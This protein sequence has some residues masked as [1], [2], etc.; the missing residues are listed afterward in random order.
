MKGN[1]DI[2]HWIAAGFL[3]L[4]LLI[5]PADC[6]AGVAVS[7]LKQWVEVKP[8][9]DALFSVD[10]TNTNRGPETRPST[11]SVDVVDFTVS[12]QGGLS[13]GEEFK[14]DRSAVDWISFNA[15]KLVL[16]PGETK[17]IKA[18]LSAPPSADGDYWAAIMVTLGNS[19]KQ[20]KGIQVVLR[21]ASG[22]FVHV[23]RR[24]YIARGDIIN[25]TVAIP[26]SYPEQVLTEELTWDQSS[27]EVQKEQAL[28]I[29]VELK[30][31]GLVTFLANGK[32]FL[33][34]GNWRRM[35]SIPLHTN[36]RRIFP[37]HSRYF[38]GVMSQPLP[39]GEYKLRLFFEPDSK[40]GRKITKDMEFSVS[41]ESARQW[42]E[43]FSRDDIQMMEVEPQQIKLTL[44]PGRLTATRFLVVNQGLST[45]A[46][47]CWLEEN[48]PSQGW[49][50]LK[51][52][53]F[54]L[55][56]NSR[57]N[58]VCS[59][60]IPPDAQPG[61]YYA[62]IHMEVERSG[63]IVQGKSNTKLHKIP[64]CITVGN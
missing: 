5:L 39:A 38:T 59:V 12:P 33:Y 50:K 51:S 58:V 47:H 21:T 17:E 64:V 49:L 40:Y 61:Q 28:K 35:A 19:R 15:G 57:R 41:D 55:A 11:V 23:A 31:D 26:E 10:I 44:T 14:H 6:F 56:P 48:G 8:G 22:V 60:K 30:N 34:S 18:K 3:A 25:T 52:T 1:S 36:R 13:F 45:V 20:E 63:L 42:A 32:A 16:Q 24:N 4:I 53:D 7:P 54:T 2:T 9:K 27:Q 62:T 29:N 37:G 46:A 43:S